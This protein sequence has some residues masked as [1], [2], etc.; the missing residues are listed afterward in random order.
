MYV[1]FG[2][3]KESLLNVV[4]KGQQGEQ[5]IKALMEKFRNNPPAE[6]IGSKVVR[7]ADYKLLIDK[8]LITGKEK[9]LDFPKSDVL[10]FFL[11]DGS[12]VSVRPSGTEPKIKYYISVNTRLASRND[13]EKETKVLDQKIKGI[14]DYLMSV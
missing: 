13:F 7:L 8:D 14:E 10:Q 9:P 11:A 12:K 6:I 4:K 5:E 3:Y 1:E 2:Y